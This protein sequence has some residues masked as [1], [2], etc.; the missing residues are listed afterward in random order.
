MF[1]KLWP[2]FYSLVTSLLSSPVW[3]SFVSW[4]K[5]KKTKSSW[6]CFL[7][8]LVKEFMSTISGWIYWRLP[9]NPFLNISVFLRHIFADWSPRQRLVQWPALAARR[10]LQFKVRACGRVWARAFGS[11]EELCGLSSFPRFPWQHSW[12]TPWT[13]DYK[14]FF[15]D[16]AEKRSRPPPHIKAAEVWSHWADHV[17]KEGREDGDKDW[18]EV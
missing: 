4:S 10:N 5:V 9:L 6:P 15:S 1:Q 12:R 2:V 7:T 13:R 8:L 17:F 18:T 3:L 11:L 14:P 16:E